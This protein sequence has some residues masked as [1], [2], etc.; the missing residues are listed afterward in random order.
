[1]QDLGALALQSAKEVTIN[2][3]CTVFA[4]S[5]V[6]SLLSQ[7]VRKEDILAGIHRSIADRILTMVLKMGQ[8]DIVVFNGGGAKNQGLCRVLEDK[9]RTRIFVPAEPQFIN[10]L[11]AALEASHL[12]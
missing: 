8:K 4:E 5:E 3:T 1:L 12:G 10:A 7:D 9:L 2:S 11:G 6:I